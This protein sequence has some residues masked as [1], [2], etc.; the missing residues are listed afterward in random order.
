MTRF[1]WL[2][3]LQSIDFIIQSGIL[4]KQGFLFVWP[5]TRVIVELRAHALDFVLHQVVIA[6]FR[7]IPKSSWNAKE[8]YVSPP[9][10]QFVCLCTAYQCE[11]VLVFLIGYFVGLAI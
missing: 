8:R 9:F 4:C 7:K 1:Y 10:I 2:N 6:A 3:Y 5:Y 11:Y